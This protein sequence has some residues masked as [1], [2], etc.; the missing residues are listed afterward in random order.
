VYNLILKMKETQQSLVELGLTPT[1]A[2][3]Y[4]AGL[5]YESVTVQDLAKSTKIK[6]PTIYHALS[7]LQEHGLVA[8][9]RVGAKL[10][11]FMSPP[12]N[13]HVLLEAK[14]QALAAQ[15]K[16][17][18][19]LLPHLVG[20]QKKSKESE[21]GVVHY[22]GIEGM[23]MVMDIAF[24]CR[25][26]TWDIIAPVN[27]FLREY[28]PE[29]A[30]QYLQ[31]R[32]IHGITSRT[33]WEPSQRERPLTP[34]EKAERNPRLMPWVMHGKFKSMMIL[35]DDKVAIFSPFDKLSAVLITSKELH[36]LFAAMFEGLWEVSE[37]Y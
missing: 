7:R 29:Y 22:S 18:D 4:L 1:E 10:R 26:R 11:F 23:K 32:K 2:G 8:E 30:K 20:Q 3:V 34:E 36:A 12:Q 33:L 9:K 21:V 24:Y 25:S 17:F 15:E 31:S 13:L 6:R 5:S 27:N 37:S 16:L 19:Q 28:D 35:F 14:R